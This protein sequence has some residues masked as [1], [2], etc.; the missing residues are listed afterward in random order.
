MNHDSETLVSDGLVTITE[1]RAFLGGVSRAF[2]YKEFDEGRLPF[3]HVGRR[4]M[5]PRQALIAYAAERLHGGSR[6]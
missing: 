1:A 5:V 6:P 4:R 3:V 2:L